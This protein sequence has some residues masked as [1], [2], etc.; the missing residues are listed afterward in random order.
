MSYPQPPAENALIALERFY[1]LNTPLVSDGD[2]YEAAVGASAFALGPDSDVANVNI[3]YFTGQGTPTFMQTISVGPGVT[4]AAEIF[5]TNQQYMPSKRPGRILLWPEERYN[6]D[7]SALFS[8]PSR[9]DTIPPVLDVIQFFGPPP[10]S[11]DGRRKD[12]RYYFQ[13]LPSNGVDD[14]YLIVPYYGR[15]YANIKLWNCPGT[16]EIM[17]MSYAQAAG[18]LDQIVRLALASPIPNPP[19]TSQWVITAG[20]HGMHDALVLRFTGDT[21]SQPTPLSIILSDNESAYVAP[22]S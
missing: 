17:G 16:L 1:R 15:R 2:I 10:A 13:Q 3:G 14:Y 22:E 9:V 18:A 8:D 5:A 12:K 4:V 20:A 6:P 7:T 19:I 11:L 21:T